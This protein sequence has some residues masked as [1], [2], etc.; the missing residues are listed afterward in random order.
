M[1]NSFSDMIKIAKQLPP[2]RVVVAAAADK[3]VLAAIA[4][5]TKDKFVQPTLVGDKSAILKISKTLGFNL[6]DI[7]IVPEKDR[8][9][10]AVKAVE[11]IN[12]GHAD[13]LM[14]GLI[15]T[16]SLLKAVLNKEHGLKINSRLSHIT[17]MELKRHR[18]FLLITDDA[19]NIKPDVTTKITI[20]KNAIK[21]CRKLGI[22]TPKIAL[23]SASEEVNLKITS[24]I[25]A[26]LI[27][28]MNRRGQI[29]DCL[30]DGP[31]AFDNIISKE[32]CR[33]KGIIT[34]VGGNADVIVVPELDAGNILL[35]TMRYF[36]TTKMAGIVMG[37]QTPIILTSRA[38]HAK[39]K[40]LS[41]VC[42]TI[43]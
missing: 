42:A 41:L 37:T 9:M 27:T 8:K 21:F 17:L 1:I 34:E 40:Y 25:D 22:T 15:E 6:D 14:K 28:M 12:Q 33:H 32:A 26:A 4:L 18:K 39:Q 10:C 13:I 5:A 43:F 29:K 20:I 16:R 11:L 31:L 36:A 2:K 7:E 19:V 35:K 30:I 23:V 24:S 38:D 3:D